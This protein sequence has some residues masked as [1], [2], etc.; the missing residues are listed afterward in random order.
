MQPTVSNIYNSGEKAKISYV[1]PIK[2]RKEEHVLLGFIVLDLDLNNFSSWTKKHA[3]STNG[4]LYFIDSNNQIIGESSSVKSDDLEETVRIIKLNPK[5][6]VLQSSSIDK[7]IAYQNLN[8]V[9][10]KV[11]FTENSNLVFEHI[12]ETLGVLTLVFIIILGVSILYANQQI[13]KT[14]L[15]TE[16]SKQLSDSAENLRRKNEELAHFTSMASHDLK[17]P[18]RGISLLCN[19][20]IEDSEKLNEEDITLL[21]KIDERVK[22]MVNIINGFLSL[23]KPGEIKEPPEKFN[24]KDFLQ[25]IF[26]NL[27][28]NSL[29]YCD[30]EPIQIAVKIFERKGKYYFEYYDNGPG[31]PKEF[32][33]EIFRPFKTLHDEGM[34]LGHGVGLSIVQKIVHLKSGSNV[35]V[36]TPKNNIGLGFRFLLEK[37]IEN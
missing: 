9:N 20:L 19:M 3:K 29:K 23:S 6:N 2:K 7:V 36:F 35:E 34:K 31:V 21:N 10:W 33:K 32:Q 27:I 12:Y 14:K 22:K 26:Q 15:L 37:G 13:K 1:F 25:E 18:I 30:K 16:A 28:S 8:K 17:T 4:V 5:E 24:I 11:V